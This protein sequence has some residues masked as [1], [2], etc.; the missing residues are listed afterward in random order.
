MKLAFIQN[1]TGQHF[2]IMYIAAVLKENNH[3]VEVFVESLEKDIIKGLCRSRPDIVGFTLV[4]GEQGWVMERAGQIKKVLDIPVVA[5]GS[6]PT[7]FPEMIEADN[8][9]IICRGEGEFAVLELMDRMQRR[10]EYNDILNLWVKK[11]GKVYKNEVRPLL[12]DINLLPF[13]GRDIYKKYP[14]IDRSSEIPA[15]FSRGCPY[16]C[17]FCYNA[18]K[19]EIYNFST[20]YVRPRTVKNAI[21]ELKRLLDD[22]KGLR[23]IA[24]VDDEIVFNK[25]WLAEFCTAYK[26]E[27]NLPFIASTRANFVTEDNIRRL[28]EANCSCL[29]VGVETGNYE[30]RRNILGKDIP[31]ETYIEAARIIKKYGIKLRTSNMFFIPDETVDNSF[32]T[33]DLNI[34]MKSDYPWGFMLQP[35]PRTAIYDYAVKRGYLEKDFSFEDIDSL[36]MTRS[37]IRLKDAGKILIIQRLFY[38]GVKIS[39]FK[40]LLHV[41]ILMPNNI[42]FDL[43]QKISIVINYSSSHRINFFRTLKLAIHAMTSQ[44]KFRRK[45][46]P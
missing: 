5:G 36:G 29:A 41:F 4:T 40:Y 11:N 17:T 15:S 44:K 14:F 35:F 21:A 43:L 2:G 34:L 31:N 26:S 20:S 24:V 23:S 46:R 3:S 6:Y 33:V 18:S 38:Y 42:F 10:E 19:K 7:Y 27:I 45:N 13:P 12:K 37:P 22:N 30:L 32:E 25:E 1:C 16:D 39:G 9:D 28:K 8:I